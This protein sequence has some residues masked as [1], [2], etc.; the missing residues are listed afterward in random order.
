MMAPARHPGDVSMAGARFDYS[1]LIE[2][3]LRGVVRDVLARFAAGGI[4]SPHHYYITFSTRYP[5]VEMP[6]YLRERYPQEI[7]VVLQYQYWDLEV[8]KDAFSVTLS[9]NGVRERLTV[10]FRAIRLFADPAAEFGLSFEV[11]MPEGA[12]TIRLPV[13]GPDEER[14]PAAPGKEA[15]TQAQSGTEEERASGG[16]EIVTLERFRRRRE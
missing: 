6:D 14:T 2:D 9:F 11:R 4:P 15:R 10:P 8:G 13:H 16:A 7:T 3:A 1:P 12:E 5:G